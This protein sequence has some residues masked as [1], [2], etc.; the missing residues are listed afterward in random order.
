[1][2]LRTLN[3]SDIDRLSGEIECCELVASPRFE[4]K[5][6]VARLAAHGIEFHRI[7]KLASAD[8]HGGSFVSCKASA[9]LKLGHFI[10]VEQSDNGAAF[11]SAVELLGEVFENHSDFHDA[12]AVV[13]C[14]PTAISRSS[15][16]QGFKDSQHF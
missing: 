4:L 12:N 16:P 13:G 2:R 3:S 8:F 6:D 7:T 1:M 15:V 9:S 14:P 11:G 10:H 5:R